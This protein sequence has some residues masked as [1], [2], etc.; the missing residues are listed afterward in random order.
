MDK[1]KK[2]IIIG[3][4]ASG[5]FTS[6]VLKKTLGIKAEVII[7]ERLEKIGKKLLATGNGRCNFTN[8]LMSDGKFNHPD[9]VDF[10]LKKFGYN[11]TIAFFEGLG[12]VSK[13]MA[14]GRTYPITENATSVLDVLRLAIDSLDV[15]VQTSFEVKKIINRNNQYFITSS[16]GD[17]VVADYVV[18]ASGGKASSVLGSNGSGYDL[19]KP[20]EVNIIKPLPGLVGLKS[21]KNLYKSLDGIR[22][23]GKLFIKD[24]KTKKYVGEKKGKFYLKAMV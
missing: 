4:G 12:L 10:S 22:S 20:Y 18:M 15:K 6:I 11:E 7:L 13:V 9:F 5:L 19:L 1:I 24:K 16:K 17:E 2:I 3:G 8:E 21:E 14:E 23:K